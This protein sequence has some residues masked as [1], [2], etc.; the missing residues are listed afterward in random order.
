M[1]PAIPCC[2]SKMLLALIMTTV[3]LVMLVTI[4]SPED[5]VMI[6]CVGPVASTRWQ[7]VVAAMISLTI[8]KRLGR[9]LSIWA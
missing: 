1:A 7:V 8:R 2:E 4:S 3:S 6:C 5:S 9:W